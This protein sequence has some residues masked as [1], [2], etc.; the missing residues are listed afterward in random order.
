[1]Q[2]V[3]MGPGMYTQMEKD[4]DNCKG[5]GEL[6]DEGVKCKECDARK[7]VKKE[8]DLPVTIP[9]GIP[10]GEIITLEGEGN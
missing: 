2:L 6:F 5:L 9:I 10:A 1:M 8:A 4:C 3:Q 7:I